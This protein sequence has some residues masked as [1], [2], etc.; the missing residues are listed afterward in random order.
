MSAK[1]AAMPCRCLNWP[2]PWHG[3][4]QKPPLIVPDLPGLR[5]KAARYA[6][7]GLHVVCTPLI[8]YD[9]PAQNP[10]DVFRLLWPLRNVPLLHVYCGDICPPR[11]SLLVLSLLRLP[12][13]FATIQA[14][15]P[16]MAFGGK[17]A[18]YWAA[19]AGRDWFKTV[20]CPSRQGQ[21]TQIKYGV[22]TQKTHVIYNGV[23]TKHYARGNAAAARKS[24]GLDADVPLLLF[25]SRMHRQKCP[26]D[27]LNAF[28]LAAENLPDIHFAM[29]GNGPMEGEVKARA[30]HLPCANRIHFADYA[31]NVPDFLAACD[32]WILPSEAENFSLAVIESL[33]R[34]VRRGCDRLRGQQRSFS[35][36]EKRPCRLRRR[37]SG[38]RPCH[39]TPFW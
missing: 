14:A 30:A 27:A 7:P 15:K 5:E 6:A 12:A 38:T 16:D 32:V 1:T 3:A 2:A 21:E 19:C 17:R 39:H 10:A 37:C 13:V 35:G 25:M 34:R 28:A 31:Q 18:A 29:V 26:L 33:C 22:P 4:A 23:D 20:V 11:L 9:T 24:L 8:R 36:R